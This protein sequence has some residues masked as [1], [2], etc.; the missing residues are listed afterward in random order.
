MTQVALFV[1][2]LPV[3]FESSYLDK[4]ISLLRATV[5]QQPIRVS[6]PTQPRPILSLSGLPSYYFARLGKRLSAR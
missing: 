5:G 6:K 2:K 3:T 1:W 4:S